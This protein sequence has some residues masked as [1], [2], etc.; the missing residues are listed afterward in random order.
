MGN[1]K[2]HRGGPDGADLARAVLAALGGRAPAGVEVVLLPPPTA[3]APVADAIRGTGVRLG[4]QS[5][6]AAEKGAFTGETAAPFLAALGCGFVLCGHSERR[7]LSGEDDAA[8]AARVRAALAA[9]LRPV[10]CVGETLEERDAGATEAV[11]SRQVAAGTAGLDAAAAARLE[12][13]Y[14]PVWAI[15]TGRTAT[16]AQASEGHG[17][18]REALSRGLGAA[19]ASA[20]RVL[21]G[22][23]VNPG[24]A[25]ALLSAPG[26]DGALVGGASLEAAGFAAIVKAAAAVRAVPATGG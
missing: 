25:E 16:P 24:N 17:T 18:A 23:S 22:G 7:R 2:M 6:H 1:W 20:V 11:I 19:A 10:L 21:Y 3:I 26:V 8:V 4:G 14:E 13:A 12:V 15:G 5:C 9:G